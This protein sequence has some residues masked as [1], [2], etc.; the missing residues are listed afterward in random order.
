MAQSSN[1]QLSTAGIRVQPGACVVIVRTEW[2]AH[3][4]DVLEQGCREAL[5]EQNVLY[6]VINVPGAF[7]IG[8]AINSYWENHK[9]RTNKPNA[10]IAL[11]CVLRG[12]TPH[13]EYVCSAVTYSI[14]RLNMC[15]P[16][17]TVF[18]VLTV[19]DQLQAD[20]RTGGRH[21]HKGREAAITA[22]KMIM[23]NQTFKK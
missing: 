12:D 1:E 9:Y 17:P 4:V 18:G 23:L 10:F 7:E 15:I 13:F 3:V 20:E 11:G 6:S 2:N 14:A 21:G 16:I 8:F 22:M 5:E 19:N